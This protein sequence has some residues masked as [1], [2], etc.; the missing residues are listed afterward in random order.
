MKNPFRK[1]V[2]STENTNYFRTSTKETWDTYARCANHGYVE[3]YCCSSGEV[4][5]F[6]SDNSCDYCGGPVIKWRDPE[7]KR[8]EIAEE[9]KAEQ[10]RIELAAQK[11]AEE[12]RKRQEHEAWLKT[13][14]GQEWLK[15]PIS[16]SSSTS[17]T[18][19]GVTNGG[20]N[21]A[22]CGGSGCGCR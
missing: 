17:S 16:S 11:R 6:A 12:E 8:R 19:R 15:R 1:N 3:G 10:R 14:A 18:Y 2:W 7:R 20:A 4:Q 22:G 21:G 13:P 5:K 9:Q